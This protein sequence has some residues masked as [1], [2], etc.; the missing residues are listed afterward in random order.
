MTGGSGLVD[1]HESVAGMAEIIEELNLENS[2]TFWAF[3]GGVVP[4]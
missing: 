3:N 2:G 1:P 4:W